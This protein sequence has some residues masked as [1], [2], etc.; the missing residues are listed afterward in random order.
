MEGGRILGAEGGEEDPQKRSGNGQRLP[1]KLGPLGGWQRK[2][3]EHK[4]NRVRAQPGA[5]TGV[6]EGGGAGRVGGVVAHR[7]EGTT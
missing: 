4:Q 7:D 2:A 1:R 5:Q 3:Q 6:A